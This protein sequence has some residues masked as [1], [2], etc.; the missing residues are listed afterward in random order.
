MPL[1]DE[2]HIL[3]KTWSQTGVV[4]YPV[5]SVGGYVCTMTHHSI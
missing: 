1:F 2:I 4:R 5:S 3:A